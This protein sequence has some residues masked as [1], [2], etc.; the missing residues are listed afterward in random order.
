MVSLKCL[1]LLVNGEAED[2]DTNSLFGE[3]SKFHKPGND[4]Y[5]TPQTIFPQFFSMFYSFFPQNVLTEIIE[6]TAWLA[7]LGEHRSAQWEVAGS[8]PGRTNTQ[9]R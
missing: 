2:E 5:I 7:Q 1:F 4:C 8:N 3:A 9:D 6:C